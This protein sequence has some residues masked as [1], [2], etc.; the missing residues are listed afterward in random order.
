MRSHDSEKI[1]AGR[2]AIDVAKEKLGE[3]GDVWWKDGAPDLN[4]FLVKNT[5]YAD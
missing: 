3:R 1:E 4:R 5:P 2:Q